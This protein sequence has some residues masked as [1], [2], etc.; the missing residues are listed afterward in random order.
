[1]A[2]RLPSLRQIAHDTDSLISRSVETSSPSDTGFFGPGSV[3]WKVHRATSHGIGGISSLLVEAL[4]PVAMAAVDQ[5][6]TY[7]N[8]PWLRANRTSEYVYTVVFG[9][10]DTAEEAAARVRDIHKRVRGV[11]PVTGRSYRAD[12]GD[13]L[14]WIHSAGVDCTLRAY[15]TYTRRLSPEEGDRYIAEM[16]KSGALVGL[17][18]EDMPGSRE[19]LDRYMSETRPELQLTPAAAEVLDLFLH[20]RMPVSVRPF[21]ALHITGAVAMLPDWAQE[22]YD[23]P[24][25]FPHGTATK[26]VVKLALRG[27]DVGM[28][29]LPGVRRARRHIR[30]LGN[31]GAA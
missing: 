16:R 12:D 22:M 2:A 28:A 15:E 1:M 29:G 23:I 18:T 24:R 26:Q 8:D 9:S 21:W 11:D 30:S 13:L 25:R 4:H 20:V 19:E 17:E 3:A 10:C 14:M 7:R 5:H 31:Q 27:L 6:S